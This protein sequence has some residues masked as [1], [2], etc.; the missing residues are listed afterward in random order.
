MDVLKQTMKAAA[1]GMNAQAKRLR[2]VSENIANADTH[3]YHR[4][5]VFFDSVY[6]TKNDLNTLSVSRPV[7]DQSALRQNF[8]PSNPLSDEEGY[9]TLSNVNVLI[10]VADA[11]EANQTYEANTTVFREARRMYSNLLDLLRR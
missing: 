7:L 8:D 4:K 2:V 9:V 5:M 10:E 3:G 11:R 6:D 1:D